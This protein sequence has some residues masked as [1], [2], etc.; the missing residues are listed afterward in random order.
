M[1][2]SAGANRRCNVLQWNVLREFTSKCSFNP[3]VVPR[4]IGAMRRNPAKDRMNAATT[5]LTTVRVKTKQ[6]QILLDLAP[7]VKIVVALELVVASRDYA[8]RTYPL[9]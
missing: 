1:H 2:W 5:N 8:S 7:P 4:F 6:G 9:G 3:F